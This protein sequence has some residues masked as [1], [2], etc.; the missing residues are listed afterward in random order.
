MRPTRLAILITL[1]LSARPVLATEFNVS[2]LNTEDRKNA[3]LSAFSREGY[4]APG[5]YLLDIWL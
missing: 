1:T 4:I 3:D 5:N 2:M